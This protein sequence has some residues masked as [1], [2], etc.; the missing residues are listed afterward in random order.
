MIASANP[1]R[2]LV[3]IIID[4]YN[5]ALYIP[6]AIE[7]VLAQTY[8]P[9]EIIIV[10]DGST[11]DSRQVIERYRDKR[12]RII[13]QEN[14]GQGGSLNAGFFASHGEIILFLDSDDYLLP[15]V[16]Q[17]VVA[18]RTPQTALF[19]YRARKVGNEGKT[20]GY[21]P[22]IDLPLDSG[23][24]DQIILRH[25]W[26]VKPPLCGSAYMRTALEKVMPIPEKDFTINADAY[27][28]DTAAF[29]GTVT[30]IDDLEGMWRQHDVNSQKKWQLSWDYKQLEKFTRF[31]EFRQA[32]FQRQGQLLNLEIP[33]NLV[34]RRIARMRIRLLLWKLYPKSDLGQHERFSPLMRDSFK[35]IWVYSRE[36]LWRRIKH[37]L[38]FLG[39]FAVPRRWLPSILDFLL[40][41]KREQL[42][43]I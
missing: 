32:A 12:I 43:K 20:L 22:S 14:R 41:L 27:M 30:L 24:C 40:K 38:L 39:V 25:G 3:S 15:D 37:S 4:N 7:S 5:N 36:G 13:F 19:H 29:H 33:P 28:Q 11:D 26:Y 16:V 10:D 18:A 6:E 35:S 9:L 34:Y 1:A 23:R 17:K 2:P 8:S 42:L 31:E 21:E